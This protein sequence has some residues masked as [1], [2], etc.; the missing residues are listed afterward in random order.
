MTGRE[1]A[2]RWHWEEGREKSPKFAGWLFSLS[3]SQC[4]LARLRRAHRAQLPTAQS[5]SPGMI[6]LEA[7][8][9]RVFRIFR[10]WFFEG[11][12]LVKG[13]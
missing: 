3:S 13:H 12:G 9:F 11:I 2:G 1:A 8:S 5:R 7:V 6:E 10:G 4:P